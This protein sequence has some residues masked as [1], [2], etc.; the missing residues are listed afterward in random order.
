MGPLTIQWRIQL[1]AKTLVA[2]AFAA[3]LTLVGCSSG[4]P[5]A[6]DPATT[7]ASA[8]AGGAGGEVGVFTWW[9]DGSE[10]VGL[11]ALVKLFG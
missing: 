5:A 10:K 3:A 4:A 2:V 6:S 8:P 1:R 9:A 11:D 7:S